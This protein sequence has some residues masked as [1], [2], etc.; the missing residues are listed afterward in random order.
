MAQHSH[1]HDHHHAHQPGS[2]DIRVQE[3]TFE[4]FIT[5]TIRSVIVIIATLVFLALVNA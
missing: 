2:M 5:F 3:R 4:G 1:D